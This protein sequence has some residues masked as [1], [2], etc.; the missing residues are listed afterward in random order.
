M[1][2]AFCRKIELVEMHE[3]RHVQERCPQRLIRKENHP[4]VVFVRAACGSTSWSFGEEKGNGQAVERLDRSWLDQA[5]VSL[6]LSVAC[7][8]PRLGCAQEAVSVCCGY[9]QAWARGNPLLA[10]E[11]PTILAS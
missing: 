10:H 5:R 1:S 3:Q 9:Q 4:A 6:D 8:E 7:S 2:F 11:L